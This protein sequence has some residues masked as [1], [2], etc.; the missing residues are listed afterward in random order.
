ML[1]IFF[2]INGIVHF[3]FIPQGQTV[4]QAYY[5]EILKRLHE[6]VCRKRPLLGPK[7]WILHYDNTPAH[8]GA[9]K[10][11]LAQI[12]ITEMEHLSYSLI[13]FRMTSGNFQK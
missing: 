2:R 6:S 10:Q 1:S 7:R 4:S 3:E 8:K 11:F 9:V 13:W 5:V 12:S